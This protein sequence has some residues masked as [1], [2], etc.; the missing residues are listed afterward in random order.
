LAAM[1]EAEGV[2]R[3]LFPIIL[4]LN[5]QTCIAHPCTAAVAQ[6]SKWRKAFEQKQGRAPTRDDCAAGE[7]IRPYA[8]R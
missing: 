3:L 5:V 8:A 2:R 6:L 4:V 7:S 1:N